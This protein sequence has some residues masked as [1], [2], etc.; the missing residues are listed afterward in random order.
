MWKHKGPTVAIAIS[1]EGT[2]LGDGREFAVKD[3]FIF[4]IAAE[5][6]TML[7]AETSLQI[8]AAVVR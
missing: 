7:R 2:I 3:G 6:T 4:F 8:Y 5:T 1:G